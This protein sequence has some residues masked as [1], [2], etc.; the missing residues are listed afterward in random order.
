MPRAISEMNCIF[1]RR[2]RLGGVAANDFITRYENEHCNHYSSDYGGARP[3][4]CL[5]ASLS[6]KH[7]LSRRQCPF[8]ARRICC[9][10][11]SSLVYVLYRGSQNRVGTLLDRRLVAPLSGFTCCPSDL[12]FDVGS[13]GHALEDSRSAEEVFTCTCH[14]D[15]QHHYLPGFDSLMLMG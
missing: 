13:I 1:I 4:K 12:H 11:I 10:W 3:F 8:D 2:Y 9:L 15:T 7:F 6:S 14:P 5:A